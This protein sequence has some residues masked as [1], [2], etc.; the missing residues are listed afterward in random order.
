M[1]NSDMWSSQT[2]SSQMPIFTMRTEDFGL[3]TVP[4]QMIF[5]EN[6]HNLKVNYLR[7]IHKRPRKCP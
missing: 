6:I 3:E 4:D 1:S 7:F 2:G 5:L